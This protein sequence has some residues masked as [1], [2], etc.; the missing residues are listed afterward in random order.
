MAND[1]LDRPSGSENQSWNQPST[2]EG[3]QTGRFQGAQH[4]SAKDHG[5]LENAIRN[6]VSRMVGAGHPE[7]A[8]A[9]AP[10]A[11]IENLDPRLHPECDPVARQM[12]GTEKAISYRKALEKALLDTDPRSHRAMIEELQRSG[13]PMQTL[14]IHLFS[15]VA[16]Q[17]G[18]QWCDDEIDFMLVAVASTRISMIINHLS[19]VSSHRAQEDRPVRRV[20]LARTGR[21][22]HTIGVAIVA[23]CFRE[24]GWMVDGGVDT[25]LDDTIYTRLS[26]T[27]YHL[28]GISVG[29]VDQLDE[30]TR[31][32]RRIHANPTTRRMKIA[33]GGPA[34]LA[35]PAAFN[36]IGADIVAHSALQVVSYA[37]G[38][39]A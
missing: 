20:L 37:D 7:V 24:M 18:N 26:N 11:S 8:A 10:A 16:A 39:R 32:I 1:N 4:L 17:L 28:L 30:C 29:Q 36:R 38:I 6:S 5:V 27:P 33:V 35:H 31:T 2:S 19:H 3:G 23:S 21:A 9:E 15:P 22:A 14:A 34:V 12:P 25:E 13:V